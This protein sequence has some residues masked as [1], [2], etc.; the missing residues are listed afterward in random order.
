MQERKTW[1][2][3]LDGS[4]CLKANGRTGVNI[5]DLGRTLDFNYKVRAVRRNYMEDEKN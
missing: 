4:A 2:Q 5:E 3:I 1:I